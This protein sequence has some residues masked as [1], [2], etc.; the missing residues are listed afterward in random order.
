M[1]RPFALVAFVSLA[2]LATAQETLEARLRALCDEH[3]KEE[4][5]VG[6]SVAV[7]DRKEIALADGF[8]FADREANRRADEKTLI[9]LAS[10]S[11]PITAVGLMRLS[12]KGKLDLQADIRTYVPEFPEKPFK[13]TARHVLTHTSGIR[14]YLPSKPDD[15]FDTVT[16]EQSLKRIAPDP[17]VSE[18]GK[19]YHYSTHA[20]T[21]LARTIEKVD[22]RPFVEYMREEVFPASGGDLDF[23]VAAEAKPNRS[24]LYLK[25]STEAKLLPKRQ[26]LSWKYAGGGMESTALGVARFAESVRVGEL[27][28]PS[29]RGLMWTATTLADGKPHVYGLGWRVSPEGLVS[30]G[31]S[32]QGSA[33]TLLV[34]PKAEVVVVVLANTQGANTVGLAQQLL[35]AVRDRRKER[36]RSLAKGTLDANSRH[37]LSSR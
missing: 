24:A 1:R 21:L 12:E 32:Q 4:R 14:H 27:V 18:P 19:A 28:Q 2:S 23:E 11:K 5:I 15:G 20:F 33:T 26:D 35:L 9:R 36:R 8:G 29:T 10:V 22:G 37:P 31:G 34:D 16:T 17:L 13:I 25:Q 3:L 7:I 30:H 6:M